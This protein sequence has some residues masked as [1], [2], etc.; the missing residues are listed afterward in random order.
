M[1][2]LT[3]PLALALALVSVEMHGHSQAIADELPGPEIFSELNGFVGDWHF[4]GVASTG[5]DGVMPGE[6]F[7]ARQSVRW[8]VP[9]Q[10]LAIEWHIQSEGGVEFSSGRSRMR[11]DDI[12]GAILNTYAGEDGGRSFKG[13]AT[14]IGSNGADFDWRGHESSGTGESLNYETTY[15][16][17]GDGQ[18]RVDFIPT[19]A[20]DTVLE[21]MQFVWERTNEFKQSI[22]EFAS[23]VGQWSRM[24]QDNSGRTVISTLNVGWGPGDRALLFAMQDDIDGEKTFQA[25]EMLFHDPVS[26][27]IRSR[28]IGATGSTGDGRFEFDMVDGNVL[29]LNRCSGVNDMGEDFVCLFSIEVEDEM[30]TRKCLE[31]AVNGSSLEKSKLEAMTEIFRRVE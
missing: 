8:K 27:R 31:F 16:L 21:P 1:R 9:M 17:F 18:W 25:A 13:V 11:W 30:L 15:A 26:K 3:G 2:M 22:G 5:I 14:L 28:F 6:P 12:A 24:Y 29:A 19:C 20:D 23:L 7:M 4:Q 10:E